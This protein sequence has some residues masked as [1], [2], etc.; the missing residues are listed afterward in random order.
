MYHVAIDYIIFM[1]L[2]KNVQMNGSVSVMTWGTV[3]QTI[4]APTNEAKK[5]IQYKPVDFLEVS[6]LD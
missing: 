6:M 3:N 4:T 2:A 5:S 1:A